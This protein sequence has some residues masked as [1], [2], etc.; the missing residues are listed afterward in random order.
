MQK[1]SHSGFS[2]HESGSPAEAVRHMSLSSKQRWRASVQVSGLRGV[3][4]KCDGI[5]LLA[6][7][8]LRG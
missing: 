8:D 5:W 3:G 2:T 4:I 1:A 6:C 7:C